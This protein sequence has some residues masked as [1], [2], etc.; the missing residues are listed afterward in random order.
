MEIDGKGRRDAAHDGVAAGKKT[1]IPCTIADRDYPFGVGRRGVGAL[2][3]FAHIGGDGTGDEQHIGMT[4][5]RD[6]AEPEALEIVDGVVERM[7]LELAAIAR[8]GIDFANGKA[9][10]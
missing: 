9:S 4:R 2:E 10:P 3:G 5:G 8:A 1:A 7:D 6:K